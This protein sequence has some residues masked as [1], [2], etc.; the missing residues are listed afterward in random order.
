[1]NHYE[2]PAAGEFHIY[3]VVSEGDEKLLSGFEKEKCL[4][5]SSISSRRTYLKGHS[6][7][8][9]ITANYT[10]KDP[11]KL[12]FETAPEGKPFFKCTPHLHFNLSHFGEF[13]FIAFSSEPV[14]FDIENTTRKADFPRLAKRFFDSRE[15]ELMNRSTKPEHIA[16]LELWTAKE[17]IIKLFG[18][19]IASGLDKTLVLKEGEGTY[20]Q[21]RVHL[22]R[23]ISGDF[24]G[25]LASISKPTGF[26]EFT[27]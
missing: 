5:F 8:R 24:L 3:R 11:S 10:K 23:Y 7:A 18:T 22:T 16:F 27:F 20:N 25:T 21:T 26:R 4:S 15:T 6:A 14:G 9:I 12:E 17:A 1:M 13:V 19:G 2:I